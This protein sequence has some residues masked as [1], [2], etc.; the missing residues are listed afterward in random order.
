MVLLLTVTVAICVLG[1]CLGSIYL[2]NRQID[3]AGS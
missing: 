1:I 2:L 3:R